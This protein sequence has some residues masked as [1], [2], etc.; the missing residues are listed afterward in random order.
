M[1]SLG[2][3]IAL[4]VV[5]YISPAFA[6]CSFPAIDRP[7]ATIVVYNPNTASLSLYPADV[8]LDGKYRCRLHTG[9]TSSFL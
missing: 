8:F 6:E 2:L 5:F 9:P 1:R 4:S 3:A 7:H